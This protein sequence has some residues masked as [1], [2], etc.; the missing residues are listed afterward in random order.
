MQMQNYDQELEGKPRTLKS[1]HKLFIGPAGTGKTTV[2]EIYGL[3]LKEFG[4][5]SSGHFQRVSCVD[6]ME[7]AVGA[8]GP[9]AAAALDRAKGGVLLIDE[10]YMLDPKRGVVGEGGAANYGKEVIDTI[11]SRLDAEVGRDI[12]VILAGYE[13]EMKSLFLNWILRSAF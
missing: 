11:T 8:S 13:D 10:A 7:G 6:I 2:A 3:A 12:C 9:K 1:L 5:L 4:F